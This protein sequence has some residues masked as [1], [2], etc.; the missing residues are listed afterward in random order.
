MKNIWKQ[1]VSFI[2]D[3]G[4]L[5]VSI[6]FFIRYWW[7][8]IR[9]TNTLLFALASL[10]LWCIDARHNITINMELKGEEK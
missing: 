4:M 3:Y 8:D 2:D 6:S 1:I 7:N 9:D 10:I 5:V